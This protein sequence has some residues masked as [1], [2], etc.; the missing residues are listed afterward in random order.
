MCSCETLY[1]ARIVRSNHRHEYEISHAFDRVWTI[2]ALS[3]PVAQRH[4]HSMVCDPSESLSRNDCQHQ[5]MALLIH[6]RQ[7]RRDTT[8]CQLSR[9]P[10][11][12]WVET[13]SSV[14]CTYLFHYSTVLS[15]SIILDTGQSLHDADP[16]LYA[17]MY[18]L[19]HWNFRRLNKLM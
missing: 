1:K 6:T 19:Q 9:V 7:R 17:C 13:S 3:S 14:E 8:T 10:Y 11:D 12:V 2:D 18:D 16:D 4:S 5:D 15:T